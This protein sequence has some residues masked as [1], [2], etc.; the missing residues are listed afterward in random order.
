LPDA[1]AGLL[2]GHISAFGFVPLFSCS[3]VPL[4]SCLMNVGGSPM[5]GGH[6][7]AAINQ[8]L[9]LVPLFSVP[10]ARTWLGYRRMLPDAPAGLLYLALFSCSLVL[11]VL[12]SR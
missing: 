1:P 12:G 2:Y 8:R 10:L 5:L 9:W 6:A 3:F 11:S 7:S 4:F